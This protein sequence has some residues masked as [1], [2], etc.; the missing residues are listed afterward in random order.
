[1][2]TLPSAVTDD[3]IRNT[4]QTID[5]GDIEDDIVS[6][7]RAILAL[8]TPTAQPVGKAEAPVAY[9][10]RQKWT[11]GEWDKWELQH[12]GAFRNLQ[13]LVKNK[14]LQY[15]LRPLYLHPAEPSKPV[16]DEQGLQSIAKRLGENHVCWEGI[17]A[18]DIEQVLRYVDEWRAS[19]YPEAQVPTPELTWLY[20]HCKAL[21]MN[22][23]SD[24]GKWEHDIALFV[25]NLTEP[26][27][28]A[29]QVPSLEEIAL[30]AHEHCFKA[31]EMPKQGVQLYM[32]DAERLK[33]VIT[34]LL[35]QEKT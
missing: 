7:A 26:T 32:F 30:H 14:P 3:L 25:S 13:L 20:T 34:A 22:C 31:Y 6:F 8:V 29:A 28:D 10:S 11:N 9:Q 27:A 35:Q 1:M 24:S 18:R 4:W 2:T 21:G 15:E 17:G 33:Q 19:T 16:L 5:T 12:L 23:K